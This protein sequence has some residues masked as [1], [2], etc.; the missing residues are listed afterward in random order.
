MYQVEKVTSR[1]A[2]AGRGASL[3]Y[4]CLRKVRNQIFRKTFP[5][6]GATLIVIIK[7]KMTGIGRLSLWTSHKLSSA[8]RRESPGYDKKADI[9]SVTALFW[10]DSNST[11]RKYDSN[12]PDQ[13][14]IITNQ[15]SQVYGF[16]LVNPQLSARGRV[17]PVI[18][19][20]DDLKYV[21]R[22]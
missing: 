22:G 13:L 6:E 16:S 2:D 1:R 10:H 14:S 21:R 17:V 11:Q 9:M 20:P 3:I 8:T 4:E 18:W 12:K 5:E 19:A 7:L 15:A